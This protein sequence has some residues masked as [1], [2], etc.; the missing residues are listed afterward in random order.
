MEAFVT[1]APVPAIPSLEELTYRVPEAFAGRDLVG[2]RVLVPLGRRRVTAIVT[3]AHVSAPVGVECKDLVSV[4][5][6]EPTFTTELLELLRWMASY[7]G[8]P[9]S[10]GT[11]PRQNRR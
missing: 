8:D 9:S 4:I 3:A 10:R 7:Y 6:D 11:T 2:C 5:D 1:A